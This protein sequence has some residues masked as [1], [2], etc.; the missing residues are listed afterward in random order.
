[1]PDVRSVIPGQR[2]AARLLA[3]GARY[4][5]MASV[6]FVVVFAIIPLSI[7]AHSGEDWSFRF[8]HL[9]WLPALGA[10]LCASAW[11]LIRLTAMLSRKLAIG[12]AGLLFCLGLFALLAQVYTPIQVG[13]LDGAALESDEP[14]L[15]TAIEAA[16]ALIAALVFIL[17]LRGRG[18]TVAAAFAGLLL[19]AAIGYGGVLL[20]T[21]E[22]LRSTA[23]KPT[24]SVSGIAGNVYHIVLDSMRS[25]VFLAALERTGMTGK[26]E[27]FDLFR[28]NV[29]N[30]VTTI[31][32]SASYFTGTY[33]RSGEFAD[34][35]QQWRKDKGLFAAA[36]DRGYKIWVYAPFPHWKT[37]HVD[38]FW[39]NGDIYELES[40]VAP[41]GLYDLIQIWLV[42][43]A[44]NDLTNEALP[45]AAGLRD[46]IFTWITGETRPLTTAEIHPHAGVLMLRRLLR[47][48]S[49]RGA[50]GQYVYAH[51]AL[52]HAPFV[53]DR[54]CHYVG[55]PSESTPPRKESYLEQAQCAVRLVA[56]FF[57][58]LKRLGRYDGATIVVH[59]DT[60][61]IGRIGKG[62]PRSQ[63][64]TLGV[65]NLDLLKGV[66]A[67][68]M[69]K[70]PHAAGQLRILATRT[71]LVDVF[72]TVMEILGL[73]P[74]YRTDG[75]SVYAI[76]PD[77][78]REALFA[79]DP[80]KKYGHAFVEVRIDDQTNRRRSPLTV[81]GPAVDRRG[82]ELENP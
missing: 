2:R 30:Y 66:D 37:R 1:M 12:L 28:N 56:T 41:V 34:W 17:L 70:R 58:H 19:V 75:K 5:L 35:V 10:V 73:E 22:H 6:L 63:P 26:F 57:D 27:G 51:A 68:L 74:S 14:A 46:R 67:L 82:A 45:L 55:Q 32:S 65:A 80:T 79:F 71:Q 31:P 52:P 47:E 64:S 9:L 29:A 33:Y 38:R 78:P 11:L 60:G 44:P 50:N 54:E 25:D 42:S 69:I 39:F 4:H 7:Y 40:R 13:P 20:L 49:L 48:E 24:R 61:L 59:A 43:L 3:P 8:H 76:R 53:F 72:P 36:S 15:Y 21:H 18:R 81:I 16:F 23:P 62:P 77:E